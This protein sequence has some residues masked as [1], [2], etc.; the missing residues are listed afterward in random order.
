MKIKLFL[1]L[2]CVSLSSLMAQ[3]IVVNDPN[4]P[5]TN[6]SAEELIQEV[7]VSGS[8]CVDINLTNLAENPDGTTNIEERS[9]GYFR[10]GDTDFPFDEGIVLSTGFAVSAEGPNDSGGTSDVGTGWDGDI[11]IKTL[12]DNEYGSD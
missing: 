12:L 1:I 9:W 10:K 5:E 7:L 2:F 8:A 3:S 6:F 11:D 4:D